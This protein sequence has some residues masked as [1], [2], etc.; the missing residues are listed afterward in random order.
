[1]ATSDTIIDILRA[2]YD[3]GTALNVNSGGS[4]TFATRTDD[5]GGGVTYVGKAVV[6]TL[7]SA[8]S[9]QISRIT[10]TAGDIVIQYADGNASF[11]NIWDNRASLTYS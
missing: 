6:G 8:A 10:E 11:D 1:M 2:V 9:W 4:S 3:G 5:V 7:P